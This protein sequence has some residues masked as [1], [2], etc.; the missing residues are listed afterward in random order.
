MDALRLKK[1]LSMTKSFDFVMRRRSQVPVEGGSS[2]HRSQGSQ[3]GM[4]WRAGSRRWQR[5][6]VKGKVGGGLM[7]QGQTRSEA[8]GPRARTGI[9]I[10]AAEAQRGRFGAIDQRV[11]LRNEG[12]GWRTVVLEG[13]VPP[14]YHQIHEGRFRLEGFAAGWQR[15]RGVRRLPKNNRGNVPSFR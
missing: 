12:R 7:R 9:G 11:P 4:R 8:P 13:R 6:F 3:P 2:G 5:C 15:G 14:G 10:G 1:S